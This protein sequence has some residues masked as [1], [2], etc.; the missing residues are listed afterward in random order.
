M[1]AL[2]QPLLMLLFRNYR[3]GILFIHHFNAECYPLALHDIKRLQEVASLL[4]SQRPD[5]VQIF[6]LK[7][8]SAGR[9]C[10]CYDHTILL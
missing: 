8:A 9:Y 3:M 5:V 1:A 10:P 2:Q 7:V 4:G 6:R